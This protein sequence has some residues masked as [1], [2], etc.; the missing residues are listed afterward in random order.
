VRNYLLLLGLV[1]I[2]VWLVLVF[3]RTLGDLNQA[4]ARETAVRSEAEQLQARLDQVNRELA[5][6]ET[7]AFLSLK[8]RGYGMGEPGERVF[9]LEPDA[10]PPPTILPLGGEQPA[11]EQVSPLEA[12]LEL[13]FGN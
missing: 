3:S 6:V 4:T 10:P 8:A 7:D 13:L 2:A 9:A 11:I 1:A 12:W 5:L